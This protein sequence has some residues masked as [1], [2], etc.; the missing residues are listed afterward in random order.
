[1]KV[2]FKTLLAGALMAGIG[3]GL[4]TTASAQAPTANVPTQQ[5]AKPFAVKLG[6]NFPTDGDVKDAVGSTWFG[7]GLSYD[8]GKTKTAAPLV[9]GAYFDGTFASKSGNEASAFGIGPEARYYF[10]APTQ[11]VNFY[12]GAGIGAYFLHLKADGSSENTTRFGGKLL[13]GA[14]FKQGFLGEL[15]YT[16]PGNVHGSTLNNWGIQVGYRF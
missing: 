13:A 12:A 5:A 16:F 7:F 4:A 10:G 6:V 8:I 1:M 3:T 2:S 15:S 14:E 11:P 9:Y